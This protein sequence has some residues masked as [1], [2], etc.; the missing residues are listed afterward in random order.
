MSD[1]K[2]M[3]DYSKSPLLP[4]QQARAEALRVAAGVL[5]SA[6]GFLVAQTKNPPKNVDELLMTADWV[7]GPEEDA[8]GDVL[9]QALRNLGFIELNPD[10]VPSVFEALGRASEDCG[11]PNCPIHAPT[12]EAR[13]L[14]P[15]DA[16]SS[17]DEPVNPFVDPHE[18]WKKQHGNHESQL[19]FDNIEQTGMAEASDFEGGEADNADGEG[20]MEPT[21][22]SSR[23][24]LPDPS[25]RRIGE[26]FV[27]DGRT[28]QVTSDFPDGPHYWVEV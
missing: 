1:E 25:T 2:K 19:D 20:R 24:E 11:H 5:Q 21:Q 28:H 4:H 10:E 15:D 27:V 23:R 22:A 7:L 14:N 3:Y 8:R 26:R 12:R 18:I 13:D 16:R 17:F 6:S 9:K